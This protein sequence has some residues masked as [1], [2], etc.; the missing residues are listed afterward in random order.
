[1]FCWS[2][3]AKQLA[4]FILQTQLALVDEE[5]LA[6]GL[7]LPGVLV[8]VVY[9]VPGSICCFESV[10]VCVCMPESEANGPR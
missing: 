8:C 6:K 5:R 9:Y 2:A 10:C 4:K 3:V 7:T 1:M